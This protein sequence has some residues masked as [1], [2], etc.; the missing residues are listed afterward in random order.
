M[1]AGSD[2]GS[3]AASFRKLAYRGART[4]RDDG[5][6][7]GGNLKMASVPPYEEG[8]VPKWRPRLG[9]VL[10]ALPTAMLLISAA[11]KFARP[12]GFEDGLAHLGLPLPLAT[13][14]GILEVACTL[15]YLIPRTTVLG[16]ILLTGYLGGAVFAHVR[17]GD[18][19]VFQV[20]LG[21]LVWGG[22]YLRDPRIGRLIP[23]R[24]N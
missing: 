14:I 7:K 17:A 10:S 20:F 1:I 2:A 5:R 24:Q 21:V 16:A 18:P 19:F 9:W 4:L 15:V 11:M 23:L 13:P 3:N 12:A 8:P 22:L 6:K